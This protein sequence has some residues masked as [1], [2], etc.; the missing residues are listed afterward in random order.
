MATITI[1]MT[2]I[3]RKRRGVR[4]GDDSPSSLSA[5]PFLLSMIGGF[6][7]ILYEARPLGG[8]IAL[9]Y[10]LFYEIV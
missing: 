2:I 5:L 3:G 9:G 8:G 4:G 6:L 1:N 7:F 10:S